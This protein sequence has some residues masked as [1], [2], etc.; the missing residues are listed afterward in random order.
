[1]NTVDYIIETAKSYLGITEKSSK[2]Q[3]IIRLYNEGKPESEYTMTLS[4]PWCAAFVGAIFVKVGMKDSLPVSASCD[5]M[6]VKFQEM[7]RFHF[8]KG[9]TPQKGDI[10]F[11]NWDKDNISDHTGIVIQNKFGSLTVIEGNKNDTVG[12]R[13]VG[14]DSSVILGYGTPDYNVHL[15]PTPVIPSNPYDSLSY[16]DR[17]AIN[18]IPILSKGSKGIWVKILQTC[19]TVFFGS[20]LEIDGKFGDITKKEVMEWQ[21]NQALEVDGIVG[22]NTWASFFA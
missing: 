5:R 1:M 17:N 18:S 2:H 16:L 7:G 8:K 9:Y 11:Y 3:E 10:I 20:D 22:K 15:E 12:Y 13:N 21:T 14:N 6:I 4:D 19:L